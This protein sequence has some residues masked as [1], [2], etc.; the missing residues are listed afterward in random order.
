VRVT[1]SKACADVHQAK[2]RVAELAPGVAGDELLAAGVL[3]PSR[4]A[5]LRCQAFNA[6]VL[7]CVDAL[8]QPFE[9]QS[10]A[11]VWASLA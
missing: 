7:P 6:V 5:E 8:L 1:I 3:P 9:R 10:A 11:A 2:T 4:Q